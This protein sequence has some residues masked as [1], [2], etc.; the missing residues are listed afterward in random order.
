MRRFLKLL[1]LLAAVLLVVAA[2]NVVPFVVRVRH[3]AADP[4]AGFHADFYLYVSPGARAHAG[5]GVAAA[6]LVQPNNSGVNS[7]DASVHRRDAW[8]MCFERH[9]IADELGVVLLVPAFVRPGQDLRIYTHALDRDVLTTER[10]DVARLDLQLIAMID[11]ARRD[12]AANGLQIE[13][14]C[15]IQGFSA[16]GMFA[17]RFAAL[18]PDR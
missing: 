15:L 7:D 2:V 16:S 5:S 6:M 8:W 18:H 1:G 4:A 13:E 10:R 11:A 14:T 9:A 12:L 17:N 3:F